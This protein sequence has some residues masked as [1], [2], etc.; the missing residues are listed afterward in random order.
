MLD[1]IISL[2]RNTLRR[3]VPLLL[4]LLA[5]NCAWSS[6]NAQEV[7]LKTNLLYD[8]T[9]TPNLGVEVGLGG[10]STLNLVYGL[11]PWKFTTDSHGERF[12]KH[13]LV[14]P[15]YRWWTCSRMN[16]H[17]F[18]VHAMGGQLNVANVD[19]PVP[20]KF[21]KGINLRNA[22][23][24]SRYQGWYGGAGLTYGYQYMLSRHWNLEGEIGVGYAHVWYDQYPCGDCG[25]RM[26]KGGANYVGLTKLGLS[27][28][29]VF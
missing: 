20:G 19:L 29:Y 12:A 24:D 7:A 10:K 18:G 3:K 23:K 25:T 14:M 6:A 28:M 11:N 8:A 5:I 21:F 2:N 15:E 1:C 22:V 27:I 17:F 9:T 16:G 4:L 26:S 13:W